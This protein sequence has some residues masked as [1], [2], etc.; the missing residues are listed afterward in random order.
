MKRVILSGLIAT[1][2]LGAGSA[3]ATD[4]YD[5]TGAWY[6]APLAQY[7]FLDKSRIAND[8]AGFQVG[9]GYDFAPH[10]AA[11]LAVSNGSFNI[12]SLG[13][14]E[15]LTAIGIDGLY[16]FLPVTAM[17]RPFVLVGTGSITDDIGPQNPH[18]LGWM[19]EAGGGVLMALGS[20]A[21]STRF[22][23]R[24]EVKY[25][26]EFVQNVAF[27]PNNPG[28]IVAGVG[29]QWMF[30]A[31]TPPPPPV[32]RELPPPPAAE[33]PP[34]PPP[35]PE[36][37][38]APAG[39]QVDADCRIIEQT[40]VVRAVDFEFNSLRLTEPARETLDEVAAALHKQPEM[41]VEI[42]GYTDSI[43]TDAYNL[44]LSQKRAQAVKAYLVDKGLSDSSLTA[45]GYGKADPIASNAS[46]EGRAQ[47]RRVAFAVTNAP[48]H[49]KVVTK[50]A[51]DASTEAAQK[52]D[53]TVAKPKQ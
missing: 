6:L 14:H 16:K 15:R 30:G 53:P 48:S 28:D 21:G 33:P 40:L 29:F 4:A 23:L 52:T 43:G 49:V 24:G 47:N 39:F 12:P 36:P 44:T 51:T 2:C 20:Q 45:K 11:E 19:A 7:D 10:L 26:R 32:A 1:A 50:D 18:A 35:A 3:L 42:Q 9:L 27:I 38:H 34:P 31:Q 46:K 37:C 5:D 22:Q 13:T 17:W 25:R 8:H 41:Q